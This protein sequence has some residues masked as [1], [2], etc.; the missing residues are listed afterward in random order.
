MSEKRRKKVLK[1][2]GSIILEILAVIF[3]VALIFSL[4][5][6]GKLWKQE[7]QNQDK[8]RENMWHIYFAEITYLDA[9]LVYN[10]TLEK[11]IDFIAL[12]DIKKDDELTF[13]YYNSDNP[14]D[15]KNP[16]WFKG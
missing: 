7:E 12:T 5:Y 9:N 14:K 16:L 8:C 10:D 2:K 6:P 11:V 1:P 15:K 3:A 13:N 4:I